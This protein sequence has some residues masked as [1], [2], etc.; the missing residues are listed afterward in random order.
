MAVNVEHYHECVNEDVKEF[1]RQ[2]INRPLPVEHLWVGSFFE[3]PLMYFLD[4]ITDVDSMAFST[5]IS[6]LPSQ[7]DANEQKNNYRSISKDN[8]QNLVNSDTYFAT[9]TEF[10]PKTKELILESKGCHAGFTKLIKI[11]DNT[12]FTREDISSVG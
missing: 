12:N 7:L 2:L 3:L 5:S 1:C 9:T 8:E 6:V 4:R 10:W 11:S